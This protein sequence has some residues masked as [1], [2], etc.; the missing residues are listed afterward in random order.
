MFKFNANNFVYFQARDNLQKYGSLL[1]D[2][3]P[4][5]TTKLLLELCCNKNN[6]DEVSA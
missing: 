6:K 2:E 5:Q 4:N 1:L 3:L